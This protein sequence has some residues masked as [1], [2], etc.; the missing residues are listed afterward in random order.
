MTK[1]SQI[2]LSHDTYQLLLELR[3]PEAERVQDSIYEL[4]WHID[5]Y[6]EGRLDFDF[7]ACSGS[8]HMEAHSRW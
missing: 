3:D 2:R 4:E 1:R 8:I 7:F 6:S 5:R